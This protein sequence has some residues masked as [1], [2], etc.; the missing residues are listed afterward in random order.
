M[1]ITYSDARRGAKQA[2]LC[3]EC[4]D[5]SPG[6]PPRDVAASR[7]PSHP[8]SRFALFAGVPLG[9]RLEPS[10]GGSTMVRCRCVS[11]R[12]LQTRARSSSCSTAIWPS[13]SGSRCSSCRTGRT[14]TGSSGSSSRGG[15]RS[16]AAR[17]ERS[18]TSSSASPR[19]A[20]TLARFVSPTQRALLVRRVVSTAALNGLAA[21]ARF[22][23]FAD[24][25]LRTIGELESGLLDPERSAAISPALRGVPRR[26]R[27]ARSLGSR[28][29]AAACGRAAAVRLR[30]VARR[31][32]LRVRLR[33]SDRRAVGDARGARRRAPR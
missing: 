20:P 7:S 33:G 10:E 15:R 21:S 2:D 23:G 13:S 26:A 32:G 25:L 4:A 11:S 6:Q 17:S 5:K 3:G 18:T 9:G 8:R 28:P 12:A 24:E 30:C 29:A 27:P 16:S 22:G 31:A 19:R 1:R 14:S